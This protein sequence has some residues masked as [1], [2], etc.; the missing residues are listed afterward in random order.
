MV[1]A[2]ARLLGATELMDLPGMDPGELVCTLEDL[3][4]INRRLGGT[5]LVL[6]HLPSLF[7]NPRTPIRILDVATGY[8]DIPRAIAHWGRQRGLHVQ[9][10]AIDTH[11][12]I[13]ELAR[14]ATQAYPEIHV[15]QGDA[16]ALPYPDESFDVV[17]ASLILHH[18]EGGAQVR[19]LRE[20]YRVARCGVLVNDLRRGRWPFLVTWL[21]LRLV[22]RSRIIHHDGPV[23]VRRGFLATELL[24]LAR[25]AGW[26][27]AR[28]TCHAFFRL[29]LVGEKPKETQPQMNANER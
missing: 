1:T 21:S 29:A 20:L 27:Q 15:R 12:Q 18:T 19:L 9:I 4:W 11:A 8:G 7:P 14:D 2:P 13:L 22:S 23:S 28:V 26:A 10:D 25:E 17:L 6:T 3:A 16:L 5:R 24:A